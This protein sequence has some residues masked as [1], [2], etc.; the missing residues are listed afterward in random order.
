LSS[1]GIRHLL[2]GLVIAAVPAFVQTVHTQRAEES[3]ASGGSSALEQ[4]KLWVDDIRTFFH[5]AATAQK[6]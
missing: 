1:R 3:A 5:E 6:R 2:V 4:P